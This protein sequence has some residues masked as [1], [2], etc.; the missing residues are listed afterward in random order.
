VLV[1]DYQDVEQQIDVARLDPRPTGARAGIC[2][3]MQDRIDTAEFG[4]PILIIGAQ[5]R[6]MDCR[7]VARIE[8]EQPQCVF[9]S[10][11]EMRA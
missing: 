1:G 9:S 10:R 7:V 11:F 8:A 3:N 6:G 4:R 2:R 5:V